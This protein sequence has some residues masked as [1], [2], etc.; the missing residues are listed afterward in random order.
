MRLLPSSLLALIAAGLA[1]GSAPLPPPALDRFHFPMGLAVDTPYSLDGGTGRAHWLYVNANSDFDLATQEGLAVAVNLDGY[2]PPATGLV[3]PALA[4]TLRTDGGSW[5]GT[6]LVF[7]D[8]ADAG[9][10]NLDTGWVYV[11][12]LGGEL[13]LA[14]TS[15]GGERILM[16]SRNE[17]RLAYID[18]DGGTLSCVG[19][20]RSRNCDQDTSSPKLQVIAG[21]GANQ[22]L[23][24]FA[25]SPPIQA[26]D[27]GGGLGPPEVFVGNLR[28]L[29]TGLAGMYGM[30]GYGMGYGTGYGAGTGSYGTGY[31][32]YLGLG[33]GINEVVA[34]YV[35]RASVDDPTCLTA[36]PIG[37]I[38]AAGVVAMPA[39]E[40]V[41]VAATGRFQGQAPANVRVL[42]LGPPSCP[43]PPALPGQMGVDATP[44]TAGIDLSA[45]VQGYDG[46]AVALSSAG[47]RLFALSLSPDAIVVLRIDGVRDGELLIHPSSAAPLPSGPTEMAVI[48]RV[49]PD[50]ARIGDLVAVT[51]PGT[52]VLAFYDDEIGAVTAAL[53]G[54]GD[55]PFAIAT[56]ARTLGSGPGAVTLPGVRL[57]ITAFGSGQIAVV[58]VPDP[59]DPTTAATIAFLGTPE[60]TTANPLNP[61][62]SSLFAMPYGYYGG[63]PGGI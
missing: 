21:N 8:Y 17:N 31:N 15:A 16:P 32:P 22:I 19:A 54:V 27:P 62:T 6:P 40:G 52:N 44:P 25:V 50:G 39:P 53:P 60:D 24:A 20:E 12:S 13:R 43:G 49:G 3:P 42:T 61:L 51:C 48:P 38:P 47:D 63:M 1:C 2:G 7:P 33:Y 35:V 26:T 41:F 18:V 28:N 36:E 37:P 30:S 55:E 11:D 45:I 9:T 34:S 59:L 23:D 58:D 29:P 10:V 57:F 46:R 56:A 14:P 5:D 4:E